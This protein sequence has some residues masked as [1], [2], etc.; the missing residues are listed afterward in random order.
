[1]NTLGMTIVA[2]I[3][4]TNGRFALTTANAA[5]VVLTHPHTLASGQADDLLCLVQQYLA[6]LPADIVIDGACFAIAGP[7]IEQQVHVTNLGWRSSA[8]QL[9]SALNFPVILMNDFVAYANSIPALG[10]EQLLSLKAGQAIG[11]APVL[12]L[13]PG[14][15]FGVAVLQPQAAGHYHP[16]ACEGG[17]M[18]L[19]ATSALQ[20]GLI[21]QGRLQQA[22]VSVESFL[23]GPGLVKLYQAMAAHLEQEV[24][25]HSA[26]EISQAAMDNSSALARQT[27]ACFCH[28][29]GQVV[30]DLVL[31]HGALGGV[32]LGGGILPRMVSFIESSDFV[33]GFSAKAEMA[34]YLQAVPI[35]LALK[36]DTA[37]IGAA[38]WWRQYQRHH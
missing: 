8:A 13:G 37:L 36:S 32:V 10:A 14:T 17:H 29:L 1:M 26:A 27:L 35:Q 3:G 11:D 23:C 15:G 28:W 30:G 22:H 34:D 19:A 33:A 21:R 4:G 38:L 5:E 12:V 25:F 16:V 20:D 18:S 24:E 7:V 2:D 9:S 6:L 31:A